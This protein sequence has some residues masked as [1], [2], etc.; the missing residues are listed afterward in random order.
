MSENEAEI[1]VPAVAGFPNDLRNRYDLLEAAREKN[2]KTGLMLVIRPQDLNP[3]KVQKQL[4]NLDPYAAKSVAER[5]AIFAMHPNLPISGEAPF[6]F[7]KN[8]N[9]SE[10]YVGKAIEFVARFPPELS[11]ATGRALSF[12]LNSLIAPEEWIS[13]DDY[14]ANVFE[15]VLERIG[16]LAEFAKRQGVDIAVETTPVTEF[17]DVSKDPEHLMGDGHTYW[18]D[19]GNPWP[20]LFWRDEI[21]R[22]RQ[23]GSR[24]AIDFCH[25]FI[26]LRTVLLAGRLAKEGRPEALSVYMLHQSDI[27][28][29]RKVSF[30]EAVL[31]HTQK[32]DIWHVNDAK[33]FYKTVAL[34]GEESSFQEGVALFEGEIPV[35]ALDTL[36]KK[37]LKLPIKYVIEVH[38]EDFT[39]SPNTK[40]SLQKVFHE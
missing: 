4:D 22:L 38:E 18:A 5:P 11:P 37:G 1:Y 26:A 27:D 33:G 17:G 39:N 8:P 31:A 36:V 32:G 25:S 19:L 15:G 40:K 34:Q 16:N 20:L 6:N 28:A 3:E 13:D 29:A 21:H 30:P 35:E 9:F 2:Y 7:L 24:V 14:W 23:K 12:H 10:D